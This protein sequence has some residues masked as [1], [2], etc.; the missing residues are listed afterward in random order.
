MIQKSYHE[1]E[2]RLILSR[3]FRD[4][5]ETRMRKMILSALG[6]SFDLALVRVDEIPRHSSGKFED[7]V[8]LVET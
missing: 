2:M 8:S 4:G 1:I 6:Q 7:F 5:E 3:P